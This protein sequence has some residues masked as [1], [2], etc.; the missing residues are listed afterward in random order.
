MPR[1]PDKA[2][3]S[4]GGRCEPF[5]P[6]TSKK[7]ILTAFWDWLYE[8]CCLGCLPG[9]QGI[10]PDVS[11]NN[12]LD[13]YT[14]SELPMKEWSR[15]PYLTR[16]YSTAELLALPVAKCVLHLADA[17]VSCAGLGCY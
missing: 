10:S 2:T 12:R 16:E 3:R 5:H 1:S 9:R 4:D 11:D 8:V 7:K 6:R 13:D 15:I 14:D 17:S